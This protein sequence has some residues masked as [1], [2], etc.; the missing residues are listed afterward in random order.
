M[1]QGL[2]GLN[3]PNYEPTSWQ[4]TLLVFAMVLV[5]YFFNVF[6]SKEMPV[7]Q[8]LLLVLHTSAFFVIIVVLWVKAPKPTASVVFTQFENEGGW[9]STGLAVMVGQISAFYASLGKKEPLIRT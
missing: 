2:I 6:A 1:I 7:V 3:D 4:G 9:S 8:N 5:L